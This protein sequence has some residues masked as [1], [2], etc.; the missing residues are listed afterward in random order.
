MRQRQRATMHAMRFQRILPEVW[1]CNNVATSTCINVHH[2]T[3]SNHATILREYVY[4]AS[5]NQA[6]A[7]SAALLTTSTTLLTIRDESTQLQ[8]SWAL[9]RPH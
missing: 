5:S 4:M 1:S 2:G 3:I 8:R 9:K 7:S 6:T